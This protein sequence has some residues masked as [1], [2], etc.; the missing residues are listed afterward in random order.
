MCDE[1][2]RSLHDALCVVKRVLESKSVVPGGGAVEAA[3]SIYL[4]NYA[5]S[6]VSLKI[7]RFKR[8]LGFNRV[9]PLNWNFTH[10]LF[11]RVPES[12]W[13][14]LSLLGLSSSSPKR[15][16]WMQ[17]KTPLTWW[18]SFAP[19]TMRLRLILN[20]RISSGESYCTWQET[21]IFFYNLHRTTWAKIDA[22]LVQVQIQTFVTRQPPLSLISFLSCYMEC[23]W[24]LFVSCR[25]GLDLV[26]GKPR[27]N[28]QAGVYEPTMVKTKSLKFAT[29]AA[30]TILRIDDLIKLFPEPKEG[31]QSYRDAVQS[32]S[33]EG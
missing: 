9:K 11:L 21:V 19:S 8:V 22:H 32:G 29:E 20:A 4:E 10:I 17:H 6:M 1:M 26:N 13:P 33:L 24:P 16:L 5:T 23:I 3:L 28:R 7:C 12:S 2:E 14:L 30:I 31:G 18:P 15:W 27:D 25:I